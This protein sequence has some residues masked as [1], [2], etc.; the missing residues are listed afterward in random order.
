MKILGISGSPRKGN[1]EWMLRR[2]L[3][4]LSRAGHSADLVLLREMSIKQCRGCLAC[5]SGGAG[6]SGKCKIHDDV[7]DILPRMLEADIIVMGTPVYFDML[8]G[9]LKNFMDRTCAIWPKLAGKKMAGIAVAEEDIGKA[10]DN[11]KTY[12]GICSM[13]WIGQATALAKLPR[14]VAH[15]PAAE[16]QVARLANEICSTRP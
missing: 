1:S 7:K 10:I 14:A 11:L 8:S 12:A 4:M 9:R 6:R 5:E 15:D 16:E 2:L 13:D 3:E